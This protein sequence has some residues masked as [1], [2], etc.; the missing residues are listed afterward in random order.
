MQAGQFHALAAE[1]A[2]LL[3]AVAVAVAEPQ[4]D[5]LPVGTVGSGG[6]EGASG[7]KACN[8]ATVQQQ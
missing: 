4:P 7:I 5:A 8:P 3:A 1:L 6:A 2:L